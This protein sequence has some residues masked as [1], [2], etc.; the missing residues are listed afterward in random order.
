MGYT[1]QEVQSE[2]AIPAPSGSVALAFQAFCAEVVDIPSGSEPGPP[3]ACPSDGSSSTSTSE[4]GSG[5]CDESPA[6][7]PCTGSSPPGNNDL[8]DPPSECDNTPNRDMPLE[9]GLQTRLRILGR[10][11]SLQLQNQS[12]RLRSTTGRRY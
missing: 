5:F 7:L 9:P 11:V 6:E 10:A 8:P 4:L 1:S 2:D 3:D 12:R